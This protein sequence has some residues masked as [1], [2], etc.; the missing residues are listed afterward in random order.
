MA[1]G[2]KSALRIELGEADADEILSVRKANA[3]AF[4]KRL[5]IGV[6]RTVE[7]Q[8]DARSSALRWESVPGGMAA[9]W[10]VSA[11]G[12]H[13][14]RVGL[15]A[16]RL[17]S[18]TEIRFAGSGDIGTV[19]G[20]FA[21]T[22]VLQAQ[23]VYWSPVLEGE[24][25]I[26][27]VFVSSADSPNDVSASISAVS[28]LFA[29]PTERNIDALAKAS[30]FCEVDLICRSASD[31]ALA[32]IGKAVARMT[33]TDGR[34]FLCTGTLLN[35]AGGAF[36]PY[37]PAAH[38]FTTQ[39]VASTLT[40]H[41]FYDRTVCGSG[42]E[43]PNYVQVTGGAT[44]LYA[45]ATSDALF[46]RLNNTPPPAA[47]FA[48]W[49]AATITVGVAATGRASPGGRLQEGEPWNRR[50]VRTM[51]RVPPNDHIL[52][53]W[54]STAT[55]V[56]EGGSSGSGIFTLAGSDFQLR[57]GLHGGSSKCTAPE[58]ERND[59]YSRFDQVYP[60]ISQYLNATTSCSYS[61]SS[62][63]TS[64]G[65]GATSGSFSVTT[66]A[67][68][69]E[70]LVGRQLDHHQQQRQRQRHGDPIPVGANTGAARAGTISVGGQTF[71]VSQQAGSGGSST[72]VISNGGFESGAASWTQSSA[73]AQ[74]LIYGDGAHSYTGSG[75]AWL[76]G[77]PSGTDNLYQNVTIPAD[78]S[79]ATLQY[80]Y[81][82]ATEETVPG[83]WDTLVVGIQN[84]TT[85][86]TLATVASY[87]NQNASSGWIQSAAFDL[88]AYRG[89]TV[90]LLFQAKTDAT[91]NT[92][93][94]VDDITFTV[95]T[96]GTPSTA[97][98]TALWW[99]PAESG[100]GVNLNHQGNIVFATLF[101]YDSGG[102]PMWL[103]MSGGQMQSDG[104]TFAGA[105]YLTTGPA[106]NAVPFTPI[107]GANLTTVGTM[108]VSFSGTNSATLTYSYNG[109]TVTK[110][111]QR[112]VY[113]SRAATCT[114]TTASRASLTNY[115]DLWWNALESGWGVNV[116]HQDNTL[117][118]T[119]F[120]YDPTGHNLWLVMSGGVRQSDGSYL[121][122]LYRTSG[123]PFNANPFTPITGANLSTV[124]TMRFRFSDG[125]NGTL[126][127]TYKGVTVTKS[128]TR[129][130]FSSPVPACS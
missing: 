126:T 122:D 69:T 82:I 99:N 102:A 11:L 124:G 36:V 14:L 70:R 37:L 57:G 112:Q 129:Q 101:T 121:G 46:V 106:F 58:S 107:T 105:L 119:L 59:L 47:I 100:W 34:T 64:V 73:S 29:S 71:T 86:V 44:L 3:E 95:V 17:P 18:S 60:F 118:A 62:T 116:T 31:P 128:I 88:T 6:G 35:S 49:N 91:F 78:A 93:F 72:S 38:C 45:N 74:P 84:P 19:Y 85:G 32:T 110:S 43:G 28:H 92:N 111:I 81:R 26:V 83:A 109:T 65:A 5:Q 24:R 2:A 123:P 97:N 25:A 4:T 55:G 76:G 40:T 103:V 16:G 22:D 68:C 61:L 33:F 104:V 15:A 127:Y 120:T 130:V 89:Q 87:S 108:T 117:F 13:A 20:P 27:E 113:G 90:R 30:E 66:S 52:V 39:S 94:F 1:P 67:G 96:S 98:Y 75:Y 115:Q 21:A 54:N 114:P 53:Q 50:R 79:Q 80:W 42:S 41:W 77:Y 9:Q 56:T 125:N 8:D 10:E 7:G 63:G 48:G 51:A 12:A 23:S